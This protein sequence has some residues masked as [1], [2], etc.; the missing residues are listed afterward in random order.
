MTSAHPSAP[1]DAHRPAVTPA[2]I[3]VIVVVGVL[4]LVFGFLLVN[5]L[6]PDEPANPLADESGTSEQAE[7]TPSAEE[8]TE[9]EEPSP[10]E[11]ESPTEE[12]SPTPDPTEVFQSPSGNIVCEVGA[13][14]ASCLIRNFD[15][16]PVDA[17]GCEADA[18]GHLRVTESGAS[19]PCDPLAISGTPAV[20]GYGETIES[21]GFRCLSAEDG[22]T[23]S[24]ASDNGF[25]VA[26]AAYRLF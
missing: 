10:A 14:G 7:P 12:E 11:D 8:P 22:V 19:M 20:L 23:C 6:A 1:D 25:Q 24:N 4:V 3:A 21:N 17:D 16:D 9:P 26:R 18:G 2:E 5:R 13:D 15:Y